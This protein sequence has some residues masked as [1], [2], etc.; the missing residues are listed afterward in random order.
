VLAADISKNGA[1]GLGAIPVAGPF[2]LIPQCGGFA[3]CYLGT[4]VDGLAQVAGLAMLIAGIAAP[5]TVLV[6][7]DIGKL[8][9]HPTPM[10]LGKNAAGF[11][12]AA[13][14]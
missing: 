11:G 7:N 13:T 10:V 12:L 4:V 8:N 3:S 5:R 2:A 6:R 9:I 1:D 14:F